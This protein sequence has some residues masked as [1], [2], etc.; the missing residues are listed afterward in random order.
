MAKLYNTKGNK[1]I[2]YY[3]KQKNCTK[4]DI[5]KL[6]NVSNTTI[7][8]YL[9]N[10]FNLSL[11]QLYTLSGYLNTPFIELVAAIHLNRAKLTIQDKWHLLESEKRVHALFK[12]PK[13]FN[14]QT[15]ITKDMI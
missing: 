7:H 12:V 13:G 11:Q 6:L 4:T 1:A 10:P 3:I 8:K 14:E 2:I 15:I 9:N 5:A